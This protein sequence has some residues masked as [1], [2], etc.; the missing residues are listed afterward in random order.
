MPNPQG[1]LSFSDLRRMWSL[2]YIKKPDNALDLL[3]DALDDPTFGQ[4][5]AYTGKWRHPDGRLAT[6]EEIE[7]LRQ[8]ADQPDVLSAHADTFGT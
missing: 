8:L 7:Q 5:T 4:S 2:L 6:P 3:R 1:P